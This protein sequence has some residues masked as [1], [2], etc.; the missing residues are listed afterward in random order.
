MEE[1]MRN[2]LSVLSKLFAGMLLALTLFTSTTVANAATETEVKNAL[3]AA[4]LGLVATAEANEEVA[5][6]RTAYDTAVTAMLAPV[7]ATAKADIERLQITLEALHVAKAN[8]ANVAIAMTSAETELATAKAV[9]AP[10]VASYDVAAANLT[11]AIATVERVKASYE[12]ALTLI[13]SAI[14]KPN[15]EMKAQVGNLTELVIN[16][17][18]QID[19]QGMTTQSLIQRLDDESD[20]NVDLQKE[21]NQLRAS[22]AAQ[23]RQIAAVKADNVTQDG[24]IDAIEADNMAQNDQNSAIRAFIMHLCPRMRNDNIYSYKDVCD[25]VAN[26]APPPIVVIP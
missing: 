8:G 6:A 3:V 1:T 18:K 5:L 7:I 4:S 9:V 19:D 26:S 17:Q 20:E 15:S 13:A 21:H 14:A 11:A 23:D 16:L 10:K 12:D 2:A 24:R 22:D 25:G